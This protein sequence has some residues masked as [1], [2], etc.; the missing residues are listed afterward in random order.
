FS[1]RRQHT[2]SKRVWSS[3]VCSSDL[4]SLNFKQDIGLR[5]N[6]RGTRRLPQK[7]L[8]LYSRSDYGQ[9]RFYTEIFEDLPYSE[10]NMLLLRN[11]RSEERRVGKEGRYV[12]CTEQDRED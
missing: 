1:S 5:I 6:G 12:R 7:S 11:S 10:F 4:G 3:D 8:R 2:S 9:S